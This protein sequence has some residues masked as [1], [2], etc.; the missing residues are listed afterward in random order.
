MDLKQTLFKCLEEGGKIIRRNFGQ[1]HAIHKKTAISI[2][3]E[4]D[5]AAE[6]KIVSL[7]RNRF[8]DHRIITEESAPIHGAGDVR[9]II[10][11]LDGTTNFA[12]HLN[13][14]CVSIG[15]EKK[16]RM[17]LGGVYNPLQNELYFAEAGRGAFLNGK[18]IRV[19]K[20][21]KLIE[22]LVVT[23]FPYDRRERAKYYLQFVRAAMQQ[24]QGLRRLGAAALD[25]CYVAR[26]IFDAYWEFNLKSW[27]IAA[28]SLIVQEAGG[29]VSGVD[30]KPLDLDHPTQILASNGLL[31][32]P[33]MR[34][35]GPHL[36]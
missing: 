21:R 23:G 20:H 2:V 4:T 13:I 9:W 19:S 17:I 34:V 30:G 33:M 35:L 29:R 28:G 15:V 1:A 36:K 26:G 31:H 32:R 11:P 10:D 25:L 16:G 14:C 12:H 7:I 27:D 3:T 5:L 22:S 24:T 18:R 8:A 6:K